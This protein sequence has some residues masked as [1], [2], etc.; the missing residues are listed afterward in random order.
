MN[1]NL[2]VV[3]R[4]ANTGDALDLAALLWEQITEFDQPDAGLGDEYINP[5]EES[6]GY[7]ECTG[8]SSE[9]KIM[10]IEFFSG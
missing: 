4:L 6:I 2:S 5:S 1:N 3:Y 7:Y 9:N 10:E 8:F